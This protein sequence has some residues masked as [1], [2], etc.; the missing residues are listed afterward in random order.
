VEEL[1][2]QELKVAMVDIQL[3]MAKSV[4]Q[5]VVEE[6]VLI[7]LLVMEV[8]EV[9]VLVEEECVGAQVAH[10]GVMDILVD[11]VVVMFVEVE[12]EEEDQLDLMVS[13]LM[14][15]VEMVNFMLK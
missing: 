12:E 10:L 3:S 15:G 6:V 8:G 2:N 4:M 9:E 7:G 5:E 11:L 14:V 13:M 1:D